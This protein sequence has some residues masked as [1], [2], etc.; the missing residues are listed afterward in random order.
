MELVGLHCFNSKL[1]VVDVGDARQIMGIM[2]DTQYGMKSLW[3]RLINVRE[4][5]RNQRTLRNLRSAFNL[6]IDP[7]R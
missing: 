1:G 4:V 3:T 2:V 6:E 5:R 7:E